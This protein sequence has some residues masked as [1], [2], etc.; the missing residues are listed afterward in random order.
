MKKHADHDQLFAADVEH[1]LLYPDQ[2]LVDKVPGTD[3]EFTVAAYKRELSKPYSKLDL[4]ED[5]D[6]QHPAKEDNKLNRS[7]SFTQG[8]EKTD[9]FTSDR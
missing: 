8:V 4:A 9:M 3:E 1:V 6:D 7:S 5:C 2:K